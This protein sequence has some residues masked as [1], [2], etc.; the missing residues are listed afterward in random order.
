MIK[1]FQNASGIHTDLKDEYSLE[2]LKKNELESRLESTT[3]DVTE[4]K[5]EYFY[6]GVVQNSIQIESNRPQVEMEK[7]KAFGKIIGIVRCNT[8]KYQEFSEPI[9]VAYKNENV[10]SIVEKFLGHIVIGRSTQN[11]D[12]RPLI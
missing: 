3:A 11:W 10:E 4:V 5:H 1:H 12:P 8:M 6:K 7:E 2:I 9:L